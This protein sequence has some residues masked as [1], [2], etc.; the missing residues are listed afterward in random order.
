MNKRNKREKRKEE[1]SHVT[2]VTTTTTSSFR[3]DRPKDSFDFVNPHCDSELLTKGRRDKIRKKKRI[4]KAKETKEPDVHRVV[5]A[6]I[7]A[8]LSLLPAKRSGSSE[9][10]PSIAHNTGL[11]D[12]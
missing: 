9:S 10:S 2:L 4:V 1:I 11:E 3:I 7:S 12:E 8:L 6:L 5:F